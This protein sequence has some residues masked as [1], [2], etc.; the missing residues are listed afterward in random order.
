METPAA[1]GR[2]VDGAAEESDVRGESQEA[3]EKLERAVYRDGEPDASEKGKDGEG[4][5][6]EPRGG[7]LAGEESGVHAD[8]LFPAPKRSPE[9]GLKNF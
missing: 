3:R 1:E 6:A 9:K 7:G 4:A 8:T 2:P 5:E